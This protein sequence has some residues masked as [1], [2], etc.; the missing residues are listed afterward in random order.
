MSDEEKVV[1]A[2]FNEQQLD[3]MRLTLMKLIEDANFYGREDREIILELTTMQNADGT[4]TFAYED[5]TLPSE[6]TFR[7]H[8]KKFSEDWEAGFAPALRKKLMEK[9]YQAASKTEDNPAMM[10]V[11]TD[12]TM[13]QAAK[14][15]VRHSGEIEH[16]AELK[17]LLIELRAVDVEA[18][19]QDG[20]ERT[21]H[22]HAGTGKSGHEISVRGGVGTAG[23]PSTEMV[24]QR[25]DR[26]VHVRGED[27]EM[28][29]DTLSDTTGVPEDDTDNGRGDDMADN[30]QSE[31]PDND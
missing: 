12:K 15:E 1:R 16:S 13:P 26:P 29:G 3:M 8:V 23:C 19:P 4:L 31:H 14:H 18:I 2:A 20:A 22:L 28:E 27:K 21:D 17:A 11:L 25:D 5:G 24:P 30:Q 9:M 6:R 10:K 7:R